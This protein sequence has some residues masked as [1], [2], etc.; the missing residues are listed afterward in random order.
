M[1][2]RFSF[3]SFERSERGKSEGARCPVAF[4]VPSFE[5]SEK[6]LSQK[7]KIEM[8]FSAISIFEFR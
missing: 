7:A 8:A 3:A 5:Q 6:D 4:I 1:P 2:P